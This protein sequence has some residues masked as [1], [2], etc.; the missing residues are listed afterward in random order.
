MT[1]VRESLEDLP[2]LA[3]KENFARPLSHHG[4]V[5]DDDAIHASQNFQQLKMQVGNALQS[6]LPVGAHGFFAAQRSRRLAREADDEGAAHLDIIGIVRQNPFH[7]VG[8]P[9]LYPFLREVRALW[10]LAARG[11]RC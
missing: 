4:V 9:R 7:I 10:W 11:P 6:D 5:V 8:V 2:V 1:T 3:E